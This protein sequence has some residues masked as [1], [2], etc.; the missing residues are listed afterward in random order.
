MKITALALLFALLVSSCGI[1]TPDTDAEESESEI[2]VETVFTEEEIAVPEKTVEPESEE[3]PVNILGGQE[4]VTGKGNISLSVRS[5]LDPSKPM[6][7][8]T[9]D[10]GPSAYTMDIMKLLEKYNG[11]ATFFVVGEMLEKRSE[12]LRHMIDEGHEIASHT[13]THTNLRKV[14]KEEGKEAM[15]SVIT[16]IK[17]NYRYDIKLCRPPYGASNA[18]VKEEAAELGIALVIWSVDTLDW[19]TKNA[20]ATF[21]A[22]K[23]EAK[24]GAIILCHDIHKPTAESMKKVIPWLAEQGYQLVT[25]QELLYYKNSGATAGK[26]YYSVG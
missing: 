9:F 24:D 18:T 15:K 21:K 2:R 11:R 5:N 19:S 23:K 20:E 26:V 25:V 10:D 12:E 6:I 4:S 16:Y 17:E 22:V 14:S 3:E 7:A 1:G 8:L 13:W